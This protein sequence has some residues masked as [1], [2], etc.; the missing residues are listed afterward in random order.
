MTWREYTD[1]I[2]KICIYDD[3]THH[4]SKWVTEL[5]NWVYQIINTNTISEHQLEYEYFSA[6]ESLG[7]CAWTTSSFWANIEDGKYEELPMLKS[8]TGI[9]RRVYSFAKKFQPYC[10]KLLKNKVQI[11][12]LEI[13]NQIYE[14][15]ED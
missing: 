13:I 9:A 7:E 1:L 10:I 14:F 12:L 11:T 3:I 8:Y 2:C 15:T 5:A 6:F 4:K